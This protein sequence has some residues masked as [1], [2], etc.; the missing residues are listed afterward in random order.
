M[1]RRQGEGRHGKPLTP[2]ASSRSSA[3]H[4]RPHLTGRTPAFRGR[5]APLPPAGFSRRPLGPGTFSHDYQEATAA[6]SHGQVVGSRKDEAAAVSPELG[7]GQAAQ[8]TASPVFGG[9]SLHKRPYPTGAAPDDLSGK[10]ACRQAQPPRERGPAG[11]EERKRDKTRRRPAARDRGADTRARLCQGSRPGL[12]DA[13]SAHARPAPEGS[14]LSL[15]GGARRRGGRHWRGTAPP[16]MRTTYLAV[17]VTPS[18]VPEC[19]VAADGASCQAFMGRSPKPWDIGARIRA[20]AKP[21]APDV[22][23][24]HYRIGSRQ[25]RSCSDAGD[26]PHASSH[27][28]GR[29]SPP[30]Q[31]RTAAPA[32]C[33]GP[34][35]FDPGFSVHRV[36]ATT[37]PVS[38][39]RRSPRGE[40]PGT[41]KPP[42]SI[43]CPRV[44]TRLVLALPPPADGPG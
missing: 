40:T 38:G 39:R 43:S 10:Q 24:N 26:A 29:P 12:D 6:R 36:V 33:R 37:T 13:H 32:S 2:D 31:T 5:L 7:E 22:F 15:P 20:D 41:H 16:G 17:P 25:Y 30:R 14:R 35:L 3:C 44:S 42:P 34:E 9:A 8:S 23:A 27:A 19:D 1:P 21:G 11:K 4:P 18:A 28:R